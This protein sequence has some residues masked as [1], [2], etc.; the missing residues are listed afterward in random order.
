MTFAAFLLFHY[1]KLINFTLVLHGREKKHG[2]KKLIDKVKR[3]LAKRFRLASSNFISLRDGWW[4]F[5]II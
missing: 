5:V 1:I 4:V 3:L 2:K